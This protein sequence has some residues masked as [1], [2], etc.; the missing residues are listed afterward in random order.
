MTAERSPFHAGEQLVQTM[1]GVREQI[2]RRGRVAIRSFMPD[3]HREFF[4]NLPFTVLAIADR[5]GQPWLPC[6][7]ALRGS[8]HQAIP[9]TSK[10]RPGPHRTILCRTGCMAVPRSEAS[11]SNCRLAAATGSMAASKNGGTASAS[12]CAS[13]RVLA[14][15]RNTSRRAFRNRGSA[16]IDRKRFA[17]PIAWRRPTSILSRPPT[18]SSSLR[19]RPRSTIAYR[20]DSMYLTAADCRGLCR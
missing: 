10:W 20:T 13:G 8:R 15:V 11:A 18:L 17:D 12:R 5:E 19:G 1:A 7:L 4:A 6:C 2:E 3:Q 14:I 16:R 9:N